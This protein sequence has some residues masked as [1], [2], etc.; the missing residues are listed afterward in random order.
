MVWG[1]A[2]PLCFRV[3]ETLRPFAA[4]SAEHM[5]GAGSEAGLDETNKKL[6]GTG[7]FKFVEWVN[8]D[9]VTLEAKKD[10][11]GGKPLMDKAATLKRSRRRPAMNFVSTRCS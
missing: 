5:P 1:T 3:I 8:D 11:W 4:I 6:I 7:P 2:D 9:H 10:Y